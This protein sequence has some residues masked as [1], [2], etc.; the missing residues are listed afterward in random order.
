MLKLEQQ[1]RRADKW[2]ARCRQTQQHLAVQLSAL[3][4]ETA[5]MQQNNIAGLDVR[6]QYPTMR[7]SARPEP[8]LSEGLPV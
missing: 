3:L 2:K 7:A 8:R 4:Q 5:G 1:Y 6:G